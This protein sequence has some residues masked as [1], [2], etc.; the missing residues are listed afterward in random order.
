MHTELHVCDC[1]H[2]GNELPRINATAIDHEIRHAAIFGALTGSPRGIELIAP[3]DPLPLLGQIEQRWP[4]EFS[5]EYLERDTA[6]RIA[7][8]PVGAT[9]H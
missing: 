7:I 8:T 3:H 9:A 5:V 2:G 4:G 1:G 6:W